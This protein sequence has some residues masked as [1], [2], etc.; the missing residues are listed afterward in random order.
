VLP[1]FP[2]FAF[3]ALGGILVWLGRLSARHLAETANAKAMKDLDAGAKKDK[4]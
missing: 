4:D 1:K 2:F 3:A